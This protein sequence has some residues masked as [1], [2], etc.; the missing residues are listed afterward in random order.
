M[1]NH[2]H[3]NSNHS[4][5]HTY[6][7]HDNNDTNAGADVPVFNDVTSHYQNIMGVPN[8]KAELKSMPGPVRWFGYFFYAAIIVLAVTF[9]VS[10]IV[11]R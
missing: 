8:K 10:Y 1:D 3:S 6:T 4:H 7:H 11:N 2:D 9:I 5:S